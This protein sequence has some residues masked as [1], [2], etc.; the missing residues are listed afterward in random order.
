MNKSISQSTSQCSVDVASAARRRLETL[1]K[2][3]GSLGDFER[4][5]VR[6]CR[7]QGSLQPVTRPRHLTVF[8]AD[9]GV[10]CEGVTAWPSD[11]SGAV[12]K[13]M[14][15]GGTAS[16]VWARELGC[17]LEVVDVGLLNPVKALSPRCLDQAGRRGT[18]NLLCEAAMSESDF[19]HA[20]QVGV[21]RA[22]TA[23]ERGNRLL[24][25]GEMGIG[26]TTAASCL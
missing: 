13:V 25:G 4:L 8:A 1:C 20:W 23:C 14:Q 3:P 5:A 19:D 21:E 24:I 6:L 9:H 22:E 7:T 18:G 11:V 12:V 26:N 15:T 2:P 17:S 16:G 10:S